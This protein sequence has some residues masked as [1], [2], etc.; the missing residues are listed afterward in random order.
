MTMREGGGWR[1]APLGAVA[2]SL[3]CW[4]SGAPASAA[5][6]PPTSAAA[7]LNPYNEQLMRMPPA[8]Q[9]A[10]LATFVGATCIGTRPFLMGVTGQGRAKGYAYW[11]LECA[12]SNSYMIQIDPDGG[13]AAIDCR[14]LRISGEGRECYKTF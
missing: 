9:A 11:S 10:K 3:W 1:L 14:T 13:G 4:A 6:A 5:Q 2:V 7:A 8:Q 12:G